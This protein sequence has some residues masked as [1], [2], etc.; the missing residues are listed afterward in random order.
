MVPDMLW[1]FEMGDCVWLGELDIDCDGVAVDE[2]LT[3]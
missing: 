3:L 1:V 2:L